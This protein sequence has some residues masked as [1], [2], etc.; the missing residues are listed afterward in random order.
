MN[1]LVTYHSCQ[2]WVMQRAGDPGQ[3]LQEVADQLRDQ[4]M[5]DIEIT[6]GVVTFRD[7]MEDEDE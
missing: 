3:A 5:T 2:E 1:D 6:G 4:G 7:P